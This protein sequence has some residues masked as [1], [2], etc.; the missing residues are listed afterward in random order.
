MLKQR[1]R[2][3]EIV[4]EQFLEAEHAIDAAARLA[5]SC[6]STLLEQRL[7][8]NLPVTTGVDAL[9]LVSRASS[10]LMQARRSFIEAHVALVSVRSEIGLA[11]LYGDESEC[12]PNTGERRGN[13][14]VSLVA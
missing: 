13:P 4:T 8:A 1:R 9:Q 7:E 5:A 6:M 11:F 12:P 2:A 14:A 3:A 10:D